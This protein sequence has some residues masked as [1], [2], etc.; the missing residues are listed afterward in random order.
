MLAQSITEI[1][2]IGSRFPN[3]RVAPFDAQVLQLGTSTQQ[4]LETFPIHELPS[5]IDLS[6]VT[7]PG[8]E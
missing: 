5:E 3:R 2:P 8:F 1:M 7:R 4:S 6:K